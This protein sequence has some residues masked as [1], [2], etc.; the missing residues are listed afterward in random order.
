MQLCP[1]HYSK[2]I[3][4]V[5]KVTRQCQSSGGDYEFQ[6]KFACVASG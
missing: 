2:I 6:L 4:V 1:I 3:G 5:L